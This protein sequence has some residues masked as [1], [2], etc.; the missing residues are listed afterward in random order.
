MVKLDQD[1]GTS[2]SG[3]LVDEAGRMRALWG[4][5]AEQSDREEHE[6]CAGLPAAVFH[7]WLQRFLQ[8]LD[9]DQQRVA[10]PLTVR[11]AAAH[12]VV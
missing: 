4:S 11:W 12:L 5:Y 8:D 3:I 2:F 7:P 10:P 1:F 9:A 6:W